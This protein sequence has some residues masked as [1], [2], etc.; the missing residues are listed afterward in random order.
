MRS[1]VMKAKIDRTLDYAP[2]ARQSLFAIPRILVSRSAGAAI[3]LPML[4]YLIFEFF[5][6]NPEWYKIDVTQSAALALAST[7]QSMWA[8][9]FSSPPWLSRPSDSTSPLSRP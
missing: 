1:K 6:I 3:A 2:P 4:H 7:W 9:F 5:S 8:H